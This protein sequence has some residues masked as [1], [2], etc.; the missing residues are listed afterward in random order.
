MTAKLQEAEQ[1]MSNPHSPLSYDI[2]ISNLTRLPIQQQYGV[3]ELQAIYG[4]V[5]KTGVET[6]RLVG[7]ATL[8]DQLF[9]T[10]VASELI[11]SRSQAKTLHDQAI[12]LLN[13]AI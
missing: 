7:V 6:D 9:F 10:L 11:M 13:Q 2:C 12:H 1:S 4:P 8:G 5:V 3:I